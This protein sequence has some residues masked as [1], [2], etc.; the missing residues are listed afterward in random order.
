VRARWLT[1]LLGVSAALI[2]ALAGG[3][4]VGAATTLSE[5]ITGALVAVGSDQRS[6]EVRYDN[7]QISGCGIL[8]VTPAVTE[9]QTTVAVALT[10]QV[11]VLPPDTACA[12]ILISATISVPLS[13]PLAGRAVEGLALH[14]DGFGLV[15]GRMPNLVGLSPRDA[16]LMLSSGPPSSVGLVDHYVARAGGPARVIS[17][18]PRGGAPRPHPHGVVT[19]TIARP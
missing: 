16:R 10:A 5:P 19:L 7:A 15:P 12:A 17:Q 3:E 9:T 13:K 2:L 8:S 14:P 6:V 4:T 18:R 11:G 1:V